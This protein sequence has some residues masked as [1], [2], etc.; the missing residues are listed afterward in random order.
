MGT[1]ALNKNWYKGL[2]LVLVVAFM[3]LMSSD[4]SYATGVHSEKFK[5]A[6]NAFFAEWRII[7]AAF[8]G[9]GALT[10]ILVFIVHMIKLGAMPEHPIQRGQVLNG[11][12]ISAITTAML[13]GITLVLTLMY[14]IVFL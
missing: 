3:V 8:S 14:E 7:L 6:W 10:S 9:I 13:G 2:A 1:F 5:E 12:L 11:L 4:V